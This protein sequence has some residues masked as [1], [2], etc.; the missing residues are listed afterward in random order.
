MSSLGPFWT[1]CLYNINKFKSRQQHV[2]C[3]NGTI[4]V[5]SGDI[6][7]PIS[8]FG[9]KVTVECVVMEGHHDLYL[10]LPFYKNIMLNFNF[11]LKVTH[12]HS[13]YVC[14]AFPTAHTNT[15]PFW[16]GFGCHKQIR[17]PTRAEGYCFPHQGAAEK[18]L[19]TAHSA[20]TANSSFQLT[21]RWNFCLMKIKIRHTLVQ[22]INLLI[23]RNK[24]LQM[25]PG[26]MLNWI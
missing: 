22:L 26:I 19:L 1:N 7:V 2:S 10:G 3:A 6:T 11:H 20:V 14:L 9:Q 5:V 4:A 18:G 24:I 23:L 21:Q 15:S 8:I 25:S 17:Y 16:S 12:C 13:S